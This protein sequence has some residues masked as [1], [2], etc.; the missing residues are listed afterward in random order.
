[1]QQEQMWLK[2]ELKRTMMNIIK[3]DWGVASHMQQLKF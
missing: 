1:M 3:L 2:D